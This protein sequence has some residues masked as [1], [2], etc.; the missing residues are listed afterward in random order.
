MLMLRCLQRCTRR[1]F[2]AIFP[3]PRHAPRRC[4]FA[5]DYADF[6]HFDAAPRFDYAAAF[7]ADADV[8]AMLPHVV[9]CRLFSFDAMPWRRRYAATRAFTLRFS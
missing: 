9:C 4:R 8:A 6:R 1:Y 3:P 7:D 5:S 2:D